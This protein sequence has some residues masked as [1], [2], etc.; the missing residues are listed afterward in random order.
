MET[1]LKITL[2]VILGVIVVLGMGIFAYSNYSVKQTIDVEGSS[3]IKAMPDIVSVYF[4]IQTTGKNASEAKEKNDK[5]TDEVLTGL[6]K[7]GFERKEIET[8]NFNIY[9]DYSWEYGRNVFKG[10]K[11]VNSMKV[12]FSAEKTERLGSVIDV[13]AN[14][15]ATMSYINFELSSE[16]LNAYKSE[17]L[18][19]ATIDAKTKAEGIASGLGKKNVKLVSISEQ[20]NFMPYYRAYDNVNNAGLAEMKSAVSNIQPSQ[21]DIAANVKAVFRV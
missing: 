9:E 6:I 15:G 5:I 1:S 12:S 10:Y 18:K 17:A 14:S 8:E 13:I 11:A 2:A 19:N 21:T 4:T 16:K 3:T 7:L 20:Y